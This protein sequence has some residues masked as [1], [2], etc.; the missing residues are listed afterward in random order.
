MLNNILYLNKKLFLSIKATS[1][2]CSFCKIDEEAVPHPFSEFPF[3]KQLCCKLRTLFITD[4]SLPKLTPQAA[5]FGFQNVIPNT[6]F[7]F[8]NHSLLIF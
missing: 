7:V 5:I 6:Y 8:F 3:I 1:S 2:L 4:F